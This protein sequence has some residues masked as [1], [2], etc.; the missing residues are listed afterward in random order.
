MPLDLTPKPKVIWHAGWC[1]PNFS[2]K[3]SLELMTSPLQ[4]HGHILRH[5]AMIQFGGSIFVYKFV[6]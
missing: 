4:R 6:F 1:L 5:F 3:I 2:R